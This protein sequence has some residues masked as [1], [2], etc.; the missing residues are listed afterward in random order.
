MASTAQDLADPLM[1]LIVSVAEG[2]EPPSALLS[3]IGV[4]SNGDVG[5]A[6]VIA[7]AA[8]HPQALPGL[9]NLVAA[10]VNNG[11]A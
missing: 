6:A 3:A 4:D 9:R 7:A 10:V 11:K 1:D 2:G 8:R 5:L